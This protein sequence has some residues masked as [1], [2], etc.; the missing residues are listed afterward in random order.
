MSLL[1]LLSMTA[2]YML[3]YKLPLLYFAPDGSSSPFFLASGLA[4]AVLLIG[5]TR[6]AWSIFL[7]ASLIHLGGPFDLFDLLGLGAASTLGAILGA[8]LLK[9]DQTFNL[10]E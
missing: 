9:R 6:Y 8:W 5:G 10:L 4:L 7:G 2:L 1:K 3:I